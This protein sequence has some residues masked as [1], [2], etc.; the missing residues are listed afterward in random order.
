MH[1]PEKG[2]KEGKIKWSIFTTATWAM[3]AT[4]NFED[5]CYLAISIL[6][7]ELTTMNIFR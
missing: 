1:V 6:G 5:Q 3:M 2:K 4:C 7:A